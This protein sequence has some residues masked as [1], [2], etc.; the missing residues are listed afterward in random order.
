MTNDAKIATYIAQHEQ[1]TELLNV[2]RSIIKK[3]PFEETVKWGMPT[4]VFN[5]K[6]LIGIGA[7][8]KHVGLWFFQGALLEDKAQILHN[9]QEAKTKA[10]RQV[11]FKEISEIKPDVLHRYL[12][13]T[14]ENQKN[15]L[16]VQISK[17]VKKVILPNDLSNYLE[18]HT[19][20]SAC[21]FKL[22]PGRQKEYAEYISS[23][24]RAKTKIDRLKKI[25][26][27]IKEG[28]GLN[29]KYK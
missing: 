29:D 1:F 19:A 17:P 21:F 22:T 6:N 3:H 15:G 20:L 13:E 8:K 12:E 11:H 25:T 9:A 27:M 26:P 5:K 18:K 16:T 24:K 4:Y 7:F 14:I 2:L 28:T 10:M 23:A